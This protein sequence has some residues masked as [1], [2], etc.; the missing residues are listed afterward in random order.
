MKLKKN[1]EKTPKKITEKFTKRVKY[2]S[3]FMS[4]YEFLV[5]AQYSSPN[6]DDDFTGQIELESELLEKLVHK[7]SELYISGRK[8][9]LVQNHN[10]VS[11]GK[12]FTYKKKPLNDSVVQNHLLGKHTIA[13][14]PCSKTTTKWFLFDVDVAL[15]DKKALTIAKCCTKQL[16][17]KLK[18]YIPEEYIHCYRSGSKGYHVVIYLDKPYQRKTIQE[19]QREIITKARLNK[20]EKFQVEIFPE[21]T[22]KESL[23]KTA[24]LPLGRNFRNEEYGS[25]FCCYV[26]IETLEYKPAQYKYFLGIKQLERSNF[27]EVVSN[28][29]PDAKETRKIY[30]AAKKTTFRVT[31]KAQLENVFSFCNSYQ[32]TGHGQRHNMTFDLALKLKTIYGLTEV[33]TKDALL[34]WLDTQEG[35]YGSSKD[36][37]IKDTLFQAKYAF[38]RAFEYWGRLV[39]SVTLTK[40]DITFFVDIVNDKNIIG[41]MEKNT[42]TILVALIRHA[43]LFHDNKFYI[44]YNQIVLITDVR[45][46]TINPCLGRLETLGKIKII[47]RVEYT[48]GIRESNTY[49]LNH[50]INIQENTS[51]YTI[52]HNDK[53]DVLAVLKHY[54]QD[55]Q[56][57]ALLTKSLYNA[58]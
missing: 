26:N 25:N 50:E 12:S 28:I 11:I 18:E 4:L 38:S 16:I 42:M 20:T 2:Y 55:E 8:D 58:L 21:I 52:R 30:K 35:R 27:N 44:S 39:D 41:I 48:K 10:Q 46:N 53:I 19:F 22:N 54:Y 40:D 56:L 15:S 7:F 29:N 31:S 6:Q 37:A 13:C 36:E 5:D 17:N 51:G 9:Y 32:I 14:Y 43:K 49:Q 47:E 33:E 24:K 3:N 1:I 34:E 45:R 57:K 23:G